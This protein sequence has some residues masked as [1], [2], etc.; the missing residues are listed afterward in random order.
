MKAKAVALNAMGNEARTMWIC[1]DEDM[2]AALGTPY[3]S[4]RIAH[5]KQDDPQILAKFRANVPDLYE[6]DLEVD[7]NA[8]VSISDEGG[9]VMCWKWVSEEQA[10]LTRKQRKV[11]RQ[12]RG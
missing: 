5:Y 11:L 4:Q 2:F 12:Q 3:I 9:Y 8:V 1:I 10:G 6:G 7:P